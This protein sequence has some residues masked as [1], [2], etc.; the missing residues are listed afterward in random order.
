MM[1]VNVFI[2]EPDPSLTSH[3]F[4]SCVDQ[5][6]KATPRG[7]PRQPRD[8]RH[9]RERVRHEECV[10]FHQGFEITVEGEG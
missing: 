3:H 8:H 5:E 2:S 6:G 7:V 1:S 4:K 10:Q 9:V